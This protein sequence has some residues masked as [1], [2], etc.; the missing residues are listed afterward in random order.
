MRL[1]ND[2]RSRR[3]ETYAALD[4]DDGVSYMDVTSDAEWTCHVAYRLDD[5][6]GI[7]RYAVERNRLT[8]A[9]TDLDMLGLRLRHLCRICLLRKISVRMK[10]LHSSDAGA[11]EA[12]VDR[13]LRLLP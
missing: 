8:L 13:I 9:E 12:L 5:L 1:D 6:H 3:L 4:A 2:K 7:H 10:G 11:P